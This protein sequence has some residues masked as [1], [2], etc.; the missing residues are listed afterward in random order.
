MTQVPA[1]DAGP[2]RVAV[3]GD[4]GGH[5][6]PLVDEL[7]R[8]GADAG[9]GWLPP[10]LTVIQVGD[11]VHR[12]PDSDGV[13]ALIDHYLSQQPTQWVQLIGNHEAH[14][15]YE[16]V[17][18]WTERISDHSI[19]TLRRW[20]ERGQM[21]AAAAIDA[22]PGPGYLVTHAG[23]TAGFWHEVLD[24]PVGAPDAATA[25]DALGALGGI[26]AQV[27]F[28][29]GEMLGRPTSTSAGPVWACAATEL[30]PSWIGATLP[31]NQV[32][33]HTTVHDWR[34]EHL[35]GASEVTERTTVDG[36]GGHETTTL[37]GGVIVGVD[38]DHGRTPRHPWRA[39]ELSVPS[40][41]CVST[42]LR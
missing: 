17:F 23:L 10:D 40:A 22:G 12:G 31:F 15:L 13:V 19:E 4:V 25:A 11:L 42:S 28:R 33:G 35:R 14:Y 8:L 37:D 26:R 2:H 34:S 32:H 36:L 24:G 6:E 41:G 21:H 20:W 29:A 7:I 38:P 18:E 27:L 1:S 3:V 30:I 5:L 9:T 39:W 16:P